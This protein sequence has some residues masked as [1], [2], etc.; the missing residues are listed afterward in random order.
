MG[1]ETLVMAIPAAEALAACCP[2]RG[3]LP[4]VSGMLVLLSRAV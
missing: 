1:M 4:A 2:V 3:L